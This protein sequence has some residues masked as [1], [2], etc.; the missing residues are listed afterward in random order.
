MKLKVV[1]IRIS[2]RK[3]VV[4]LFIVNTTTEMLSQIFHSSKFIN[5]N[6][7]FIEF[8][9]TRRNESEERA[10]YILLAEYLTRKWK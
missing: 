7:I 2:F 8:M 10:V 6:S 5:R 3:I 4:D 9:E 1:P